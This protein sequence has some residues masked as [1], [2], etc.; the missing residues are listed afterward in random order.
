MNLKRL[1]TDHPASVGETYGQHLLMAFGFGA[2]M[3]AAGCACL[4]HGVFPWLF[5]TTGSDAIRALHER[6]VLHRTRQGA[7]A[8]GAARASAPSR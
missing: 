5:R 3:V 4:L 2:R 1:F 8:S 6:M 7:Q